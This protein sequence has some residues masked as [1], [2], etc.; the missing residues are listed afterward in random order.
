MASYNEVREQLNLQ[1]IQALN[2]LTNTFNNQF[3]NFSKPIYNMKDNNDDIM[4]YVFNAFPKFVSPFQQKSLQLGMAFYQARRQQAQTNSG[5]NYTTLK[6]DLSVNNILKNSLG[7][8]PNSIFNYLTSDDGYSKLQNGQPLPQL[9]KIATNSI[10]NSDRNTVLDLSTGDKWV[11][12]DT[13]YR[14]AS[15]NGCTFCKMMTL[16]RKVSDSDKDSF[17]L[18]CHCVFDRDFAGEE[19]FK[20]RQQFQSKFEDDYNKAVDMIKSNSAGDRTIQTNTK[21]YYT[22]VN[23]Q[24]NQASASSLAN[25]FDNINSNEARNQRHQNQALNQKI[26]ELAS[27]GFEF[28]K[29]IQDGDNKGKFS[30]D[31][32]KMAEYTWTDI[33]GKD[34]TESLSSYDAADYLLDNKIDL[35]TFGQPIHK[36]VQSLTNKNIATAIKI[37]QGNRN[38]LDYSQDSNFN[39]LE[40]TN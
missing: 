3:I 25:D 17:H 23:K 26:S 39:R 19:E 9:G 20:N 14:I 22:A 28:P 36:P 13:I 8:I 18:H 32:Y 5:R 27:N 35:N 16:S 40:K 12:S 4:N 10:T 7:S 29:E 37:V 38:V 31:N 1:H 2:L 34:H 6:T 11:S 30:G 21:E 33:D 15:P 24:L